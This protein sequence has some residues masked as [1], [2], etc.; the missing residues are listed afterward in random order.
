MTTQAFAD[1]VAR[2][3]CPGCGTE[4]DV[5]DIEPLSNIGCP[6]CRTQMTV[7]G[8]VGSLVLKKLLGRGTAG[9]VYH[10]F[11]HEL[12]KDVAV[13][14]FLAAP[15]A[16]NGVDG[17][18]GSQRIDVIEKCLTEARAMRALS[19]PNIVQIYKVA[20]KSE[21]PFIVMELL[22]GDRLDKLIENRWLV[23]EHRALRMAIDIA[24]GLKA[25]HDAGFAHLDVK[26]ANI[27]MDGQGVCKLMDYDTARSLAHIEERGAGL[28][29]TPYYVAP[30]IIRR[31]PVD[32]RADM[33]SLGAT[34]FHL[35]AQRP[36]FQGET[37]RDVVQE[38]L[39]RPAMN[40]RE[41][42]GDVSP[43]TAAV[44]A[45]M[46]EPEPDHRYANYDLLLAD[47]RRAQELAV[48]RAIKAAP[49][50]AAKRPAKLSPAAVAALVAVGIILVAV[51]VGIA[52]RPGDERDP[53]LAGNTDRAA[54][55]DRDVLDTRP[56]GADSNNKDVAVKDAAKD[57]A[58]VPVNPKDKTIDV[59]PVRPPDPPVATTDKAP[60][61]VVKPVVPVA[62][63]KKPEP[64]VVP[65]PPIAPVLKRTDKDVDGW[66]AGK[67]VTLTV[68]PGLLTVW[69]TGKE[70]SIRIAGIPGAGNSPEASL[71][72]IRLKASGEGEG[73]LWW[74]SD[75]FPLFSDTRI[76]T[77]NIK[78]DSEW[79]EY[80]IP[81]RAKGET[82]ELRLDFG[83]AAGIFEVQWIKFYANGA[84]DTRPTRQ[85]KFEE[86]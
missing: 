14:V 24:S 13:K 46:L 70:P 44:I 11:D 80:L 86:R 25:V 78:H 62:D 6:R 17:N 16:G 37:S 47:L 39:K 22:T 32:F 7:P 45:R 75:K 21:R 10:A 38:R 58:A 66:I 42:R 69:S 1:R 50:V 83:S 41:I 65:D 5:A 67:D 60:P 43:E 27:Q 56:G 71:V 59:V 26:P 85:W 35:I 61:E 79:H 2:I 12:S 3:P 68:G 8:V 84:T 76:K 73:R 33:Y 34:L 30:E 18:N 31:E 15:A 63:G 72:E 64:P 40:L 54:A 74:L 36:P 19:H 29:G 23:E 9:I 82:L 77:F 57:S 53:S 49:A 4:I 81:I 28:V 20:Q 55:K 48:E 52:G 51:V